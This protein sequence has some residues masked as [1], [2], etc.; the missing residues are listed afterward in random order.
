[1][2]Y[3]DRE[4]GRLLR[5]LG[6]HGPD[7]RATILLAAD[8]GESLGD[9]GEITHA[10]FVY[11]ATQRVPL[12]LA[13]PGITAGLETRPRSL[14][15]VAATLLDLYGLGP[16]EIHEGESLLEAPADGPAYL[17]T[18][19]TEL[20]R[21]WS[22]LHAVRTER[23]K[24]IRA[25]RSELYDLTADPGERTNLFGTQPEIEDDMIRR[26][27]EILASS[28][29][30]KVEGLDPQTAEQ[31]R[32]LG[33]VASVEVGS[34][35]D[36]RKDPKDGVA[37]AAALFHGEQAYVDGRFRV[38]E[39]HLLRAIQLDPKGKEA[40]SF[41]AGTY[42]GMQRYDLAAEYARR[43]LELPPHLNE[44]PVHSTLGESLLALGQPDKALPHLKV[45]LEAKPGSAKLRRLIEQARAR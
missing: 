18:K 6:A 2:S 29:P 3:A 34:A 37:G 16:A 20:L 42:Y 11:D 30:T 5:R 8:H 15:D 1:V 14:T 25:P 44:G 35:P 17:E 41:L 38:A 32:S 33:Y 10:I 31:L 22:P 13:G 24:Y 28:A 12:L 9:H 7:R 4:L 43:S 36:L 23:W 40:H 27:D 26:L 19:H 39:R 21:G 45:A